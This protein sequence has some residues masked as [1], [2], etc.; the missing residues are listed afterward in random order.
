VKG[1]R[2]KSWLVNKKV[3]LKVPRREEERE[4]RE[5]RLTDALFDFLKKLHFD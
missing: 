5:C 1:Q 2:A 4:R 3:A